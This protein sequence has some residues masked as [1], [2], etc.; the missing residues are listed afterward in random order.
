MKRAIIFAML[1]L[2]LPVRADLP[3][4]EWRTARPVALPKMAARGLVYLPL[5]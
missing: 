5:D 4:G 3:R 2:A 1:L